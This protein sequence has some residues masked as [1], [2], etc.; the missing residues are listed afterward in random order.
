MKYKSKEALFPLLFATFKIYV[1][2]FNIN[3]LFIIDLS[4]TYL[5]MHLETEHRVL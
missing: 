2:S 5:L 3:M 4:F 1:L